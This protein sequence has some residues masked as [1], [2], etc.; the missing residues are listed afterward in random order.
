M[1]AR[2]DINR[3]Y[4]LALGRFIDAYSTIELALNLSLRHYARVPEPVAQAIF[5]NTRIDNAIQLLNRLIEMGEISDP[6]KTDL[7]YLFAQLSIINRVRNDIIHYGANF[8]NAAV[9]IVS[10]SVFVHKENRIRETPIS[11][12]LLEDLIYDLG[13]IHAHFIANHVGLQD[14][15]GVH[16]PEQEALLK[17]SWRYKRA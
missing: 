5:F 12:Q 14:S 6:A 7:K 13:K 16:H 10:T 1:A 8:D 11:P 3:R 15:D 2:D 17:A 4:W 9:A